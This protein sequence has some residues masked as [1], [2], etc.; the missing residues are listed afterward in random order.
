[1]N[2]GRG[3]LDFNSAGEQA[4]FGV[5]FKELL[6]THGGRNAVRE[7]TGVSGDMLSKYVNSRGVPS[8]ATIIKLID[9]GI[10]GYVTPEDLAADAPWMA[11]KYVK[12]VSPKKAKAAPEPPAPNG[13]TAPEPANLMDA[14]MAEP[15]LTA[16]QR[17]QLAAV[18]ALVVNG[19]DLQIQ[20]SPRTSR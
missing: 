11:P 14:I 8:R 2:V 9:T 13:E 12:Q 6:D 18:V 17:A 5:W 7:R 4:A 16:K 20:I 10:I 15:G 1:M 19:V 3:Y